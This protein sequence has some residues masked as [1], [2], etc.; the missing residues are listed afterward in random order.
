MDLLRELGLEQTTGCPQGLKLGLQQKV[1][2]EDNILRSSYDL[3]DSAAT[4]VDR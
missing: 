4:V 3:K 2:N 1:L